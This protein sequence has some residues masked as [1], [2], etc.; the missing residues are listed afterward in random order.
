MG[1][2]TLYSDLFTFPIAPIS[3]SI[4]D[5]YRKILRCISSRRQLNRENY[6][7]ELVPKIIFTTFLLFWLLF[8]SWNLP[9]F[10]AEVRDQDSQDAKELLERLAAHQAY[11]FFYIPAPVSQDAST[12]SQRSKEQKADKKTPVDP[13]ITMRA[14]T[15]ESG[16]N[17]QGKPPRQIFEEFMKQV[18]GGSTQGHEIMAA[19][20]GEWKDRLIRA[21]IATLNANGANSP[22]AIKQLVQ[23]GQV[24][25]DHARL[26]WH[27]RDILVKEAAE[28]GL[29]ALRAKH[30]DLHFDLTVLD[31]GS[32]G[33][34]TSDIDKTIHLVARNKKTGEPISVHG[35]GG[36]M[37]YDTLVKEFFNHFNNRG[38][39]YG[40]Q[41]GK[42][43]HLSLDTEFFATDTLPESFAKG[44]FY[45]TVNG[46]LPLNE[47]AAAH[48]RHFNALQRNPGPSYQFSGTVFSQVT[49]RA[50]EAQ[51]AL[52]DRIA[53]RLER[54]AGQSASALAWEEALIFSHAACRQFSTTDA[55]KVRIRDMDV[56]EFLE[57]NNL[58]SQY[59]R[60]QAAEN[61]AGN[62]EKLIHK[63]EAVFRPDGTFDPNAWNA[64]KTD[65]AKYH[66]R[67]GSKDSVTARNPD[68]NP[69]KGL[70]KVSRRYGPADAKARFGKESKFS[71]PYTREVHNE[72]FTEPLR[73]LYGARSDAA[74]LIDEDV[75]LFWR[76]TQV[77]ENIMALKDNPNLPRELPRQWAPFPGESYPESRVLRPLTAYLKKKHPDRFGGLQDHDPELINA[78][79][80]LHVETAQR[81]TVMA[82]GSHMQEAMDL[83]LRSPHGE[84]KAVISAQGESVGLKKRERYRLLRS[85]VDD[86]ETKEKISILTREIEVETKKLIEMQKNPRGI[87]A[88]IHDTGLETLR[89]AYTLFNKPGTDHAY[90]QVIDQLPPKYRDAVMIM[91]GVWKAKAREAQKER[92]R[93]EAGLEPFDV[94]QLTMQAVLNLHH[95]YME[96]FGIDTDAFFGKM[97]QGISSTANSASNVLKRFFAAN[98]VNYGA[99]DSAGRL[100]RSMQMSENLPWGERM[101]MLSETMGN[102][103]VMGVPVIGPLWTT[104]QGIRTRD[105][106][107]AAGGAIS[108]GSEMAQVTLSRAA[109]A[110]RA[111]QLGGMAALVL[112]LARTTV[113]IVG[114]E[115][116]TPIRDHFL[117]LVTKGYV[118]KQP[119]GWVLRVGTNEINDRI[120]VTPLMATPGETGAHAFL[121]LEPKQA[122]ILAGQFLHGGKA[123]A[124]KALYEWAL[125]KDTLGQDWREGTP[126]FS[127]VMIDLATDFDR[128]ISEL[129]GRPI[130][131]AGDPQDLL[132]R[133]QRSREAVFEILRGHKSLQSAVKERIQKD[134]ARR[135]DDPGDLN[136]W[137][138]SARQN[139]GW[140]L[141]SYFK[142]EINLLAADLGGW[143]PESAPIR[144]DQA[145]ILE[146]HRALASSEFTRHLQTE[147]E[148]VLDTPKRFRARVETLQE[149]TGH[150]ISWSDPQTMLNEYVQNKAREWWTGSSK[151]NEPIKKAF[152]RQA[153]AALAFRARGFSDPRQEWFA[154]IEEMR[155]KEK[156]L[157]DNPPV[158]PEPLKKIQKERL[159][160]E[161]QYRLLVQ[162]FREAE[163][164][165]AP[166]IAHLR[167]MD[168]LD[169]TGAFDNDVHTGLSFVWHDAETQKMIRD[170]VS[171]DMITSREI[172]WRY[173]GFTSVYEGLLQAE[174]NGVRTEYARI[175]DYAIQKRQ[176]EAAARYAELRAMAREQAQA[177]DGAM[178][179]EIEPDLVVIHGK[180]GRT[181]LD[182]QVEIAV[183]HDKL[184][185]ENIK[186]DQGIG[187]ILGENLERVIGAEALTRALKLSGLAKDEIA[188][189]ARIDVKVTEATPAEGFENLKYESLPASE[190]HL[191]I[192]PGP[193]TKSIP[194]KLVLTAVE[195]DGKP[196]NTLGDRI[197]GKDILDRDASD[198]RTEVSWALS[199]FIQAP[200]SIDLG[201]DFS[202]GFCTAAAIRNQRGP[203][204][205]T[206]D[207][208][209]NLATGIGVLEPGAG[210]LTGVVDEKKKLEVSRQSGRAATAKSNPQITFR[211]DNRSSRPP[212]FYRYLSDKGHELNILVGTMP[213]GMPS[214]GEIRQRTTAET[215]ARSGILGQPDSTDQKKFDSRIT[216]ILNTA[217]LQDQSALSGS[218]RNYRLIYRPLEKEEQAPAFKQP[219]FADSGCIPPTIQEE[220]VSGVPILKLVKIEGPKS[221]EITPGYDQHYVISYNEGETGFRA[222][223]NYTYFHPDWIAAMRVTKA[224]LE[225]I[226]G[227]PFEM[228]FEIKKRTVYEPGEGCFQKDHRIDPHTNRAPK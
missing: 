7:K 35:P 168:W 208:T 82:A 189:A 191:L 181:D 187:L 67:G 109:T 154:K 59:N 97:P 39:F 115:V 86:A 228:L 44:R 133:M 160:L 92:L 202:V 21:T 196:V 121:Y 207:L 31:S 223:S 3:S 102:E 201:K 140:H 84:V 137:I 46:E 188:F 135:D 209:A 204:G 180:D 184:R 211:I 96:S 117:Q 54:M 43:A 13:S 119:A 36:L 113:E 165:V 18:V 224:P 40:A 5:H 87:E 20:E 122:Q 24:H 12:A 25:M 149:H 108:L 198:K 15:G 141:D 199:R 126:I 19:M 72:L 32:Y 11:R 151:E 176:R 48:R 220:A 99:F 197:D 14:Y 210:S 161:E 174:L 127:P 143:K 227:K 129:A 153:A 144:D 26:M 98:Y 105:P 215:N 124:A 104:S 75:D 226:L 63:T 173:R 94:K 170:Q 64:K 33:S 218:R 103:F 159:D 62:F 155:R 110:S 213:D 28:V 37:S 112:S 52:K 217:L 1:Q 139:L 150:R 128:L 166:K 146:R 182:I 145:R 219:D 85:G 34:I 222:E 73:R 194:K 142:R 203:G 27:A 167:L 57:N 132:D 76:A 225:I 41:K 111:A 29:N 164:M 169:G 9:C 125:D 136:L 163:T 206:I 65:I 4:F 74:Q 171:A 216:I 214:S 51:A 200:E 6:R 38:T 50:V 30:P 118:G 8:S 134:M 221:G 61:A 116:F 71:R 177:H 190:G 178:R 156:A 120:P 212:D 205:Q 60:A 53:T 138:L 179:M 56:A 79:K 95:G 186:V 195:L 89:R 22:A 192:F 55:G 90:R 83:W 78:A 193:K 147:L 66:D 100:I 45:K 101:A 10:A 58:V 152:A 69:P 107:V 17:I 91:E 42:A 77:S 49:G 130:G 123:R 88:E 70:G 81:Q 23:S 47:A 93:R 172:L 16:E 2:Y 106:K 185:A 175:T 131:E 68:P 183:T 162:G 158:D 114:H 80:K 148:S 157:L